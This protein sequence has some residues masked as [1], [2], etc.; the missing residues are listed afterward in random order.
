MKIIDMARDQAQSAVN[1][2]DANSGVRFTPADFFRDAGTVIAV[3]L[4]LGLLA[5]ILLG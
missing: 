3:C 5:Q 4:A 2:T 1:T